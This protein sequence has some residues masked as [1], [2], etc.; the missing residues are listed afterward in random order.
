MNSSSDP[1]KTGA[2]TLDLRAMDSGWISNADPIGLGLGLF[3]GGVV[4][5]I[6]LFR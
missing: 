5:L 1:N 3:I 2:I 6:I 4:L